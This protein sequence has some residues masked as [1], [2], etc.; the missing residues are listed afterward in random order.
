VR[1]KLGAIRLRIRRDRAGGHPA[2]AGVFIIMMKYY[3]RLLATEFCMSSCQHD[4]V[5]NL[6]HTADGL[7]I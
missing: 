5:I 3:F 1:A 2:G 6:M 7:L 4:C